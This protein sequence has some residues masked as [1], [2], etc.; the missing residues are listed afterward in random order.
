MLTF[1]DLVFCASEIKAEL[2]MGVCSLCFIVVCDQQLKGQV[3]H[4]TVTVQALHCV[5]QV[6]GVFASFPKS[7]RVSQNN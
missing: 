7:I 6:S 3:I 1:V 4:E 5:Y 2:E